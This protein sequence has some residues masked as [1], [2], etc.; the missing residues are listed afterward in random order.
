[1]ISTKWV[2]GKENLS[3]VIGIREEVFSKENMEK[4]ITDF[5][6]EFAFNAV[7]YDNDEPAG[8]GRLLFKEGKYFIDMLCVKEKFRGQNYGDLLIRM[9][10]RKAV[11]IGATET[12]A[13]VGENLIK[14]FEKSGFKTVSS[15][16][17]VLMVKEGDVGGSCCGGCS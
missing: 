2:Q 10:V 12:Y 15:N 4:E 17:T 1:M 6:D 8:T 13:Q 7:L 14:L 3:V 5:Y 9:L 11:T 16:N